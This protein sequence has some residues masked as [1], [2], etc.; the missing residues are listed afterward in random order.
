MKTSA[1][2]D[3]SACHLHQDPRAAAARC[4]SIAQPLQKLIKTLFH[5]LF[6]EICQMILLEGFWLLFADWCA[7]SESLNNP[8]SKRTDC[9]NLS[10]FSSGCP[11]FSLVDTAFEGIFTGQVHANVILKT[12]SIL[13]IL[14]FN[15]FVGYGL[16]GILIYSFRRAIFVSPF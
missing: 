7:W 14:N 13:F 16:W 10:A 5:L 4:P 11:K 15:A 3:H 6:T 1:W 9:H 8:V 2:K 12:H